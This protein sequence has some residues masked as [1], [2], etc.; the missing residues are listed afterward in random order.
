MEQYQNERNAQHAKHDQG[1]EVPEVATA[2]G[3]EGIVTDKQE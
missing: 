1:V 2:M 3:E